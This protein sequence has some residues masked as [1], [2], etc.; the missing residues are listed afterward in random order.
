MRTGP[1]SDRQVGSQ[2]RNRDLENGG[3]WKAQTGR[4]S[5]V[6]VDGENID[7]KREM[8]VM[9]PVNQDLVLRVGRKMKRIRV[10]ADG[11]QWK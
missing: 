6:S 10:V 1:D 8:V 11:G 7:I 3:R 9:V 2:G 5:L 4:V